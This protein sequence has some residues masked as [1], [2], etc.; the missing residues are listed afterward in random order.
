MPFKKKMSDSE[1]SLDESVCPVCFS[2]FSAEVIE[3]HVNQCIESKLSHATSINE[4]GEFKKKKM[5]LNPQAW[6]CLAP[7][8]S[9]QAHT[10]SFNKSKSPIG[11]QQNNGFD[12]KASPS[13]HSGSRNIREHQRNVL[14]R[15]D[16]L[17][18]IPS[19]TTADHV[20]LAEKM[21]P[22]TLEEYFGQDSVVGN[23]SVLRTLLNHDNVPTMI[24]WGPPGCGKVTISYIA[25]LFNF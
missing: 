17:M 1:P 7:S 21:R 12:K 10:G 22:R 14:E 13:S 2:T 6:G 8:G 18:K 19:N 20:P 9:S 3:T 24:L 4:S 23:A 5:K 25:H 16:D 11:F 15:S